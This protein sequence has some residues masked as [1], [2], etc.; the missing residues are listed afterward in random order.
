[1][2]RLYR[3]DRDLKLKE[4]GS[5]D[6]ARA[7]QTLRECYDRGLKRYVSDEEAISETSFGLRRSDTDFI[8]ITCNGADSIAVHSDR[9]VFPSKLSGVF[10]PKKHLAISGN[11]S[12]VT[13]V[14]RDYSELTREQ[15]EEK[16]K[17]HA[18][19]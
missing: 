13:E 18:C 16:Y 10:S 2:V 17:A 11:L 14:V 15:F 4:L 6:V 1:M 9:L 8:E 7:L 5:C 19:R 3:F 12:V